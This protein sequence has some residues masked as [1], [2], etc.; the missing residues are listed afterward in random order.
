[1]VGR[2]PYTSYTVMRT[3][4]CPL[5][6]ALLLFLVVVVRHPG[7]R[8]ADEGQNAVNREQM[9]EEGAAIQQQADHNVQQRNAESQR[10]SLRQCFFQQI[11]IHGSF[12]LKITK[13]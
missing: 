6:A 11:L 5:L 3:R 7:D 10:N 8:D 12:L 4:L 13:Y 9:A 2:V 1:M